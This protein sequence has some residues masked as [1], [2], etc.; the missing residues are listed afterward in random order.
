LWVTVRNHGKRPALQLAGEVTWERVS[1]ARSSTARAPGWGAGETSEANVRLYSPIVGVGEPVELPFLVTEDPD[2]LD[3]RIHST[4]FRAIIRY[5][6]I[7]QLAHHT[8]ADVEGTHWLKYTG[9]E[10]YSWNINER[11]VT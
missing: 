2:G 7:A 5:R 11:E 9:D 8:D 4:R 1:D 10:G 6:D 3:E